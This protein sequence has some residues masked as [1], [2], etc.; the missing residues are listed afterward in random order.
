MSRADDAGRATAGSRFSGLNMAI[1]ASMLVGRTDR[2]DDMFVAMAERARLHALDLDSEGFCSDDPK[3]TAMDELFVHQIPEPLP[4]VV[5]HHEHWR[6]SLF[7]IVHPRDAAGRRDHPHHGDVPGHARRWTRSSSAASA[8]RRPSV[9]TPAPYDGDPHT[10]AV[11]PVTVEIVEPFKTVTL[12]VVDDPAAP[13]R[14]RPHLHARTAAYGLRR[15]TMKA[16]HETI[17]DQSHMVQSG[18]FSRHRHPPGRAPRDRRLVGPARPLVGHP[19]PRPL[20]V[21]D[22]AGDPAARRHA[23][24]LVLGAARTAPA[25]TPTA[26][27]RRP[28]AVTRSRWSTSA[29]T[30]TGPTLPA[31]RCRYE[32][33]GV[34][35]T[36]IAGHV[37]F[38][39]EGGRVIGIDAE[40]RWAQRYGAVG[41]GLS[42]VV[43]RTDDGRTG[44]AIYELTGAHH[45]RYFPVARGENLPG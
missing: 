29:T 19:Q 42:E 18:N 14:P 38:T 20:P 23:R 9:A 1:L 7:F 34:D 32:R 27:G 10:M 3:L 30:S 43:V 35:V 26:A 39:L 21:L 45:H 15:G 6:E 37:D 28:T 36:G 22:V 44:T 31:T 16:G 33:D 4:N 24:R 13:R 8:T 11:G 40:G 25:S 5:T 17:W 12:H 41:G 2:G